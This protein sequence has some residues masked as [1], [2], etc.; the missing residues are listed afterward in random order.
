[1]GPRWCGTLKRDMLVSKLIRSSCLGLTLRA[2]ITSDG[3]TVT[4]LTLPT[5]SS[6]LLL[7]PTVNN[8]LLGT[9]TQPTVGRFQRARHAR[10]AS[11]APPAVAAVIPR[12][13]LIRS[14]N[15][16]IF[17]GDGLGTAATPTLGGKPST[18]MRAVMADDNSFLC[19]TPACAPGTLV[20]ALVVRGVVRM[21]SEE[22]PGSGVY[23]GA[24][25]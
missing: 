16:V 13:A 17:W 1:M 18:N 22:T 14:G 12:R 21:A 23:L 7:L 9:R 24:C 20:R 3:R 25:E 5:D 6:I 2:V 19:T 10:E 15:T 11:S 4:V 8:G